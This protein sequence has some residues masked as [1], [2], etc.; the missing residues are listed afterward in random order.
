MPRSIE[1]PIVTNEVNTTG[2]INM[3]YASAKNNVKRFIYA[4]S[5]STYGDS[6]KL[7][8]VEDHIG[9]PMSP[10]AITKYTNELYADVF[11]KVYKIDTIGLRY[12][13]VFG[14][15]QNINGPYAAVIPKFIDMIINK[16]NPVINGDGSYSRDFTHVD[17]VVQINIRALLTKRGESLNQVYNAAVGD[18][19][20]IIQLFELIKKYLEGYDKSVGKIVPIFGPVRAGDV[21]HSLASIEKAKFYLEYNPKIKIEKG[22]YETVKWFY[23]QFEKQN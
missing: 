13:N 1:N 16:K 20:S 4:A 10:Y 11:S 23:H 14:K 17:N 3:L 15:K 5:S 2:F 18:R 7:P 19:T 12:F 22:L 21:P 9:N 8:K 6:E